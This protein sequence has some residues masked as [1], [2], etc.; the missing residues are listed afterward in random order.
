MTDSANGMK[1][2]LRAFRDGEWEAIIA[3]H[4]GA[5]P[6][7]LHGSCDARAFVPLAEDPECDDLRRSHI[8]VATEAGAVV[9]FAAVDGNYLGWLYVAPS[10][11]GRGIGRRLLRAALAA[12]TG[13]PWTIVL[14]GNRRAINLYRS[15]GFR[16]VARFESENAGYPC[17]C[18]RL[19]RTAAAAPSTSAR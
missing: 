4:D 6:D 18:L 5:R 17:T 10:H 14:A 8:I 11:Y 16:E 7:E 19:A 2:E 1:I 9:G 12:T 3:I 13:E 15:E